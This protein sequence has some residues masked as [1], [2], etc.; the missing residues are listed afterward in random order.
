M[1]ALAIGFLALALAGTSATAQMVGGQYRVEGTN[2]DGSAYRGTAT[3]TPS[4]DSTCRIS[5]Q[6]GSTSSGICMMA[7]RAFA[8][9]NR[10]NGAVGLVVYE[11][12][13]DGSM[14]GVWTIADQP[15]A[16]TEVL[17]PAK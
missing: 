15:G 8:A 11:M 16:G 10:M 6:T 12:Q 17:T 7:G 1:R 13:P 9:S 5:W 3:I 4:S 14:K 2:A